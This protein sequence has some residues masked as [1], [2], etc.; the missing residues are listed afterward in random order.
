MNDD[1]RPL[2]P[3]TMGTLNFI[4]DVGTLHV[5]WDNGRTL[6]V[7]PGED[8]FQVLP[9]EPA[10]LRLYMPISADL[11]LRDECGDLKNVGTMDGRDLTDFIESISIEME[12]NQSLELSDGIM[13]WYPDQNS[14][15]KVRSVEF[16]VDLYDG[17]LWAVAECKV[18][19]TLLPDELDA[20]K[21]YVTLQAKDG[22]G[23]S[24]ARR[25]IPAVD[26]GKI[27]IHLWNDDCWSIQTEQEL[28]QEIIPR[29]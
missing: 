24:F 14:I 17:W 26:G 28:N 20:L 16:T 8:D 3:G 15:N 12:N 7:T 5:S 4:D 21:K 2:D 25:S 27:H 18:I 11:Y 19:G 23:V 29:L 1:P 13:Y 10:T 9:P 6:G 22:W